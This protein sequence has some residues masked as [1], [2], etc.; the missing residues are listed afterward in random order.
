LA[1]IRPEKPKGSSLAYPLG[2][3]AQLTRVWEESKNIMNETMMEDKIDES[4]K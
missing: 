3:L 1:V 4:R 2:F